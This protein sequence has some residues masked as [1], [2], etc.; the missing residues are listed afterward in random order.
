M[1]ATLSCRRIVKNYDQ[2]PAPVEVL[3]NIDLEVAAGERLA[4]VGRS[5][6][7]KSTLLNILG[8]LDQP[9]S[10]EVMVAGEP[11]SRLNS[12]ARARLRNK[13][14]GF[15]YQFHHLLG[16]FSALENVAMP[17]LIRGDKLRIARASAEAMLEQVGLG[18]RVQHKPAELSGG[19]RQR[20]AIARA[21]VTQPACVLLDEP[22]GNLDR[23]TASTV[24]NLLWTLNEE[25]GI[26]LVI[27]THDDSL[28]S[29]VARV[30]ELIDGRLI[31]QSGS[32]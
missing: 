2:G 8:G 3:S 9:S 13:S 6:S 30:L 21:L 17:L 10:G 7:G 22:T 14:L 25:L 15:V 18:H 28:Q 26:A 4:I 5:G 31:H 11:M 1:P 32:V 24:Q 12:S 20:V 16:E 27:V 23:D 29:Q 19:E